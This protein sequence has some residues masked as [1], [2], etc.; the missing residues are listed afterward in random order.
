M[1]RNPRG[2]TPRPKQVISVLLEGIAKTSAKLN[3]P[4]LVNTLNIPICKGFYNL[5]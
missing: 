3:V 2:L 1:T 4:V 5:Q